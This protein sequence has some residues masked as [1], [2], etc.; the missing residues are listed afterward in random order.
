VV[1]ICGTL[2][3]LLY[4][5][6]VGKLHLPVLLVIPAVLIWLQGFFMIWNARGVFDPGFWQMISLPQPIPS[7][8]GS[9]DRSSSREILIRYSALLI[10]CIA[11]LQI[12]QSKK[13][14]QLLLYYIFTSTFLLVILGLIQKL[15][16]ASDILWGN[17][18]INRYFF[19]TF[20][21]HANAGAFFNLTSPLMVIIFFLYLPCWWRGK[22]KWISVFQTTILF[23]GVL[24]V[25]LH[26]SRAASAIALCGIFVVAALYQNSIR[27]TFV[28]HPKFK[29]GSLILLTITIISIV[30]TVGSRW[31]G[32]F[33]SL[34][35]TGIRLAA[36]RT[37]LEIIPDVGLCGLG[38]GCFKWVFPFY[39]GGIKPDTAGFWRHL[40]QDYLQT[41][42]EWG[43]IGS[44]FW[45]ALFG[46][47][48]VRL[49]K[50]MTFAMTTQQRELKLFLGSIAFGLTATAV[51]SLGDFPMQI[52]SIQLVTFTYLGIIWGIQ[53]H[54]K[55][56]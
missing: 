2:F 19:S 21:Y 13:S 18:E 49:A 52:F 50:L 36:Y 15:S 6:R 14:F 22:T 32:F 34:N 4:Y 26:G 53:T 44:L 40:H 43:F 7:L 3:L 5:I 37:A 1:L 9:I 56:F 10:A 11:V 55:L 38:P 48:L 16:G 33:G 24:S 47:S 39:G 45:L 27:N 30:T 41:F 8:P 31:I 20:R 17:R 29:W 25:L 54:H 23:V 28:S 12:A 51:H 35:A 46:F 42:L